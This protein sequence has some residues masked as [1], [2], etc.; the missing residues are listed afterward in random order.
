MCCTRCENFCEEESRCWT[1][2][3]RCL[4]NTSGELPKWIFASALHASFRE[5]LPYIGRRRV[6][7]AVEN[8]APSFVI[9]FQG[10]RS[11]RI[12]TVKGGKNPKKTLSKLALQMKSLLDILRIH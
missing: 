9:P 11:L 2:E 3:R 7:C 12:I 10:S 1:P 8:A 4:G 5:L 6:F